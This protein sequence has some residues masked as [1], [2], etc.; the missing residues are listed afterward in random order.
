MRRDDDKL[1]STTGTVEHDTDLNRDPLTGEPGAH[2]VGTG[3]GAATGAATGAAIGGAVGGPPGAILGAAIG[4]IAGGFAGKGVAEAVNPTEEEAFW[5]STYHTRPYA[6]GRTYEDLGPAYRYGWESRVND[7]ERSWDQAENDLERGWENLKDKSKL[8]WHEAKDATRDAWNRTGTNYAA[9]AYWNQN[10]AS[11]PYGSGRNYDD[12]RP[13]YRYGLE[14]RHR[15]QGRRYEDVEN[16]LRSGWENFKG[17]SKLRWEEAKDAVHDAFTRDETDYFGG[18]PFD[19]NA[20]R[21]SFSA[22]PYAAGASYDDFSPAYRYGWESR[23]RYQGRSFEDVQND[24]ERGWEKAKGK[25][26]LTWEKAKLAARDAWHGV[27][28]ALPGDADRDGR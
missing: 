3:V 4:G 21:S 8:R 27:E 10:Y 2:P 7:P 5:R 26:R 22:R 24:L 1:K 9:D 13:A 14:S 28:R 20:W 25:S 17:K 23:N 19:D 18:R 12:L 6:A 15:Y 16:D 11:Q